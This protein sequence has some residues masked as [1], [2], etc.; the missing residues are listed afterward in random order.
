MLGNCWL[1]TQRFF[2]TFGLNVEQLKQI[3]S[4]TEIMFRSMF[5]MKGS[6]AALPFFVKVAVGLCASLA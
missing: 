2:H 3:V 1:K 6:V 5:D 4:R